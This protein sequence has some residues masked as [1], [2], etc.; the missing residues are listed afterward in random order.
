MRPASW[1]EGSIGLRCHICFERPASCLLTSTGVESAGCIHMP[2][3]RQT[4]SPTTTFF[5]LAA[6][7][8]SSA[9]TAG[10]PP[11]CEYTIDDVS[12]SPP[13]DCLEVTWE[14]GVTSC[15]CDFGIS[16]TNGC[17]IPF[18]PDPPKYCGQRDY[19]CTT[20]LEPGGTYYSTGHSDSWRFSLT[21][22]ESGAVHDVHVSATVV[23][24]PEGCS[25]AV[26]G[27]RTSSS[28]WMFVGLSVVIAGACGRV[29][30][31]RASS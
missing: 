6:I 16:V 8:W 21:N 20:A 27:G 4:L 31:R 18:E 22:S 3:P 23:M 10:C 14:D 5:A 25:V 15:G 2:F 29:F 28:P 30:P 9:A 17:E 13:V 7:A 26:P 1:I 11:D 19:G 24:V 12:I